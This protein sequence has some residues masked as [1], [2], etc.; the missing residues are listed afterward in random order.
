MDKR[1]LLD[2]LET[3]VSRSNNET[4][5]LEHC[6]KD[7]FETLVDDYECEKE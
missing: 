7:D 2:R 5:Y 1:E 3:L 4:D 6:L